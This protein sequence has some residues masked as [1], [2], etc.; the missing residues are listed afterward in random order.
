MKMEL[1]RKESAFVARVDQIR[2]N[3]AFQI[4]ALETA[5]L[6]T[7]IKYRREVERTEM[8][9]AEMESHFLNNQKD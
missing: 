9:L 6:E 5:L 2:S 7:K 4:Q 1:I 8:K 3:T